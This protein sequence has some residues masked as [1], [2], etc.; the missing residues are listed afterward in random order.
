MDTIFS[1]GSA[2]IFFMIDEGD[3]PSIQCKMSLRERTSMRKVD[4]LSLVF[5]EFYVPA[6]TSR[7]SS[8]ETSLQLSK[9]ITLSVICRIYVYTGATS[10]E[11]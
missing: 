3:I 8:I 9:N 1:V 7:L 4:V 5:I 11:T 6:L 2:Q 10:K